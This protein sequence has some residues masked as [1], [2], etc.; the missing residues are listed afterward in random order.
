MNNLTIILIIL[1]A[2]VVLVY[3]FYYRKPSVSQQ[4]TFAPINN[5][6]ESQSSLNIM[7][8]NMEYAM[9]D[10]MDG[11]DADY[12][13]KFDSK[14]KARGGYKV[15]N[16]AEGVRGN[17][18]DGSWQ[19]YFDENN[20]LIE[21]S[22]SQYG[23]INGIDE[24]IPLDSTGYSVH[25]TFNQSGPTKC[26][27]NQDCDVED[28]YDIENYL[29]QEQN[30]AW[31][32]SLD[33]NIPIKDRHLI[34]INKPIGINTIGNSLK[35]ASYDLRGAPSCPKFAITPFNNSSI[36][37]DINIRPGLNL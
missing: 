8:T 14:N 10:V 35:N 34:N 16:Y 13:N 19:E 23:A 11:M 28:L 15:I 36:D 9:D 29:P 5:A 3:F 24:T 30:D 26:G 22:Q 4:E 32:E 33:Q 2:C 27:S 1:T 12:L 7:P 21:N 6:Y 20:N 18:S 31:W 17:I 25:A 37:P